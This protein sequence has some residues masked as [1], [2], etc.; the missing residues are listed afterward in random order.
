MDDAHALRMGGG[1]P[2]GDG[3]TGVDRAII[4][5]N[6]FQ[7]SEGLG[8]RTVERL[9]QKMLAVVDRDNYADK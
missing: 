7:V 8:Q 2:I 3:T 1:I 9:G 4:D 6:D 5:H